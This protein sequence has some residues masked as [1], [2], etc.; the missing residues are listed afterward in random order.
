MSV[1]C[2][3]EDMR[4]YEPS[5]NWIAAWPVAPVCTVSL[6]LSASPAMPGLPLTATGWLI[7]MRAAG[8]PIA[9][10]ACTTKK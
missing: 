2:V 10:W 7:T 1:T 3:S 9:A 4:T 8:A 5:G 6:E